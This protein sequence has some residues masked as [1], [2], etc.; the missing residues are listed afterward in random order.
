MTLRLPSLLAIAALGLATAA[1]AGPPKRVTVTNFPATQDVNVVGGC[2]SASLVGFT[3][4]RLDG[5]QGVLRLAAA[6][7]AEFPGSHL[8]TTRELSGSSRVPMGLSGTAWISPVLNLTSATYGAHDEASGIQRPNPAEWNCS[9]WSSAVG[10]GLAVD[11]SGVLSFASCAESRSI[12][13]CAP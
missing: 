9:F 7:T 6:C 12:A 11:A 13:C 4:T 10:S 2:A 8:C 5:G 3:A 1:A